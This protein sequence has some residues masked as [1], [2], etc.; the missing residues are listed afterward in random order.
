[1]D[2]S[3]EAPRKGRDELFEV[4]GG[5]NLVPYWKKYH[6]GSREAGGGDVWGSKAKKV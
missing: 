6:L 1:M 2:G 4:L 3:F 5:A